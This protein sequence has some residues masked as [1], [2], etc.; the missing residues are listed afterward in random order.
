MKLVASLAAALV[1]F[2][3]PFA[4][5][6]ATES[7]SEYYRDTVGDVSGAPDIL[8][9]SVGFSDDDV[10]SFTVYA[11]LTTANSGVSV[12]LNTDGSAATGAVKQLGADYAFLATDGGKSTGLVR[13]QNGGWED[14]DAR[15]GRSS[16]YTGHV[17][18]VIDRKE[19]GSPKALDVV[20]V[21]LAGSTGDRVPNTGAIHYN[22][23]PLKLSTR[24]FASKG[25]PLA[26]RLSFVPIRSDSGGPL[27]GVLPYCSVH[28]GSKIVFAKTVAGA[29]A[30]APAS[31]TWKFAK[32]LRGRKATASMRV[33]YAGRTA[34][35]AASFIIH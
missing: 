12:F 29:K 34:S 19:L 33:V 16:T 8:D 1:L 6:A 21:S 13:W 11:D 27:T 30:G 23:G 18:F 9:V 14:V 26:E 35:R 28:V 4:A 5:S 17:L 31:C 7:W 2:A 20:A 24:A 22:L 3:F 10:V 32:G 15:T 25:G